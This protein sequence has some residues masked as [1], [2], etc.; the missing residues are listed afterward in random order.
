MTDAVDTES[1][2]RRRRPER[3]LVDDQL[4]E[5]LTGHL[6]YEE[7]DP[8]G[9]GSGN[10]RNPSSQV[11]GGRVATAPSCPQSVLLHVFGGVLPQQ[12]VACRH[13]RSSEV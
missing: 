4:A 8:A 6:G 3:R 10:S 9:W 5:E 12:P 1:V 7:G 2:G 11:R 13:A